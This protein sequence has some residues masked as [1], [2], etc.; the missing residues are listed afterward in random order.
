LAR[1]RCEL[2]H[3]DPASNSK[4][5]PA[6]LAYRIQA[7]RFG[8]LDHETKKVLDRANANGSDLAMSDR[9]IRLDQKRTSLKPG[10]CWFGN[11]TGNLIA[12]WCWLMALPGTDKPLTV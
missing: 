6:A 10:P 7:D 9:L 1:I 5:R 4:P 2:V 3:T 12:S 11:G 8:D